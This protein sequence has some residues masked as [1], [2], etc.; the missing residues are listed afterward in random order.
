MLNGKEEEFTKQLKEKVLKQNSAFATDAL[1]VLAFSYRKFDQMP[2]DLS[3]KEIEKDMVFVGLMAMID[4]ARKEA[5]EAIKECKKA[6]I[7]PIMI[8]GDY[9][10][11]AVEI[12]KDLGILDE[13][14][15][16]IMGRELNKMTE[17]EICEVVKTC[18]LYT[19]DAADDIAL[20]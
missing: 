2:K 4:P 5:K 3:F 6:G 20:V 10:E 18:L 17:D 14:S 16:A 9:L 19:S 12:A 13:N 8:T 15:K 11:T 7:T 1:R